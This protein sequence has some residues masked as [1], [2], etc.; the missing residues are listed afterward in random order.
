MSE[1]QTAVVQRQV[2]VPTRAERIARWF[3][4]SVLVSLMPL[5]ISYMANK[6]DR[7]PAA[8]MAATADGG[9]LLICTT[10]AAGALGELIPGERSDGVKKLFVGGACVFIVM[11]GSLYYSAVKSRSNADPTATFAASMGVLAGTLLT[12]AGCVYLSHGTVTN[13]A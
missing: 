5:L 11:F 1:L 4:F 13:D 8:A 9:L 12:G 3:M 7:I 10:L 6:L 2:V